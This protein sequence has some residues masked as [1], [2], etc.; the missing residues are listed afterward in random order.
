MNIWVDACPAIIAFDQIQRFVR[1]AKC[2]KASRFASPAARLVRIAGLEQTHLAGSDC[3]IADI[4][5]F[6]SNFP[7]GP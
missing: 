4:A 7:P 3:T 2:T 6:P 5:V 1:S